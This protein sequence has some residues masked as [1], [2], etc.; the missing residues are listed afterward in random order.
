MSEKTIAGW[1]LIGVICLVA[2]AAACFVIGYDKG[3]KAVKAEE[4]KR[5]GAR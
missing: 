4:G 3:A 5:G 2:V 1:V